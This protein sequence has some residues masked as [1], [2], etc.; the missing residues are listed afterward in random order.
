MIELS[1]FGQHLFG[2]IMQIPPDLENARRYLKLGT[3]SSDDVNRAAL[4][5]VEECWDECVYPWDTVP[6][7]S[8]AIG[9]YYWE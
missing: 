5:F 7:R 9:D 6:D 3:C 2:L 4:R 1:S 8:T